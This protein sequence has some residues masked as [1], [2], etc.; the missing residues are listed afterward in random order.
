MNIW[1]TLGI[2]S[3]KNI[4]EIK[5]AYANKVKDVH[6]E[7]DP[8]Q[9][10]E[11][12]SAYQ[13]ALS[14]AKGSY[15]KVY[16]TSTT[17]SWST[18][19]TSNLE[20]DEEYSLAF[21]VVGKNEEEILEILKKLI[22]YKSTKKERRGYLKKLLGFEKF[23]DYLLAHENMR[24]SLSVILELEC[25]Q[26]RDIKK[27]K[28]SFDNHF[29]KGFPESLRAIDSLLSAPKRGYGKWFFI[30]PYLAFLMALL[31]PNYMFYYDEEDIQA[32]FTFT[33]FVLIIIWSVFMF[34]QRTRA[35]EVERSLGKVIEQK[36]GLGT[37]FFGVFSG[38]SWLMSVSCFFIM[39]AMED[40]FHLADMMILGISFTAF[41]PNNFIAVMSFIACLFGYLCYLI[42]GSNGRT[43]A[44]M[45]YWE[46][47]YKK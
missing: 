12:H 24:Q 35:N 20:M 18:V 17:D 21:E 19:D 5:K 33:L 26:Q 23:F 34:F 39:P 11:L 13:M 30:L 29:S 16:S 8:V 7:T 14:Y 15:E 47:H 31:C 10:N 25:L 45:D 28:K 2:K 1:N 27:I 44:Q 36:I 3:T 41:V 37:L 32:V 4:A 38:G 9:F 40:T 6:P 43:D 22:Y 46:K 42:A